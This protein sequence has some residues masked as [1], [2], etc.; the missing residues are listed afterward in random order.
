MVEDL[1][2][3]IA[4]IIEGMAKDELMKMKDEEFSLIKVVDCKL[5]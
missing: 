1:G 4:D 3:K 2:T 5:Q